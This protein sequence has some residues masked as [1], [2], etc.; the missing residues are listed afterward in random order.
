MVA[1]LVTRIT[2][3]LLKSSHLSNEERQ[4]LTSA[5]LDKLGA[6]PLHA[7]IVVDEAGQFFVNGKQLDLDT[8]RKLRES[9]R[10]MMNNFARRFVR[11]QVKYMA[12]NI[13]VH[14]NTSPD[15]GLFAKTA[16]YNFQEEDELY[17]KFIQDEPTG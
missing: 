15:Q 16:L 5:L 4:L 14:Q 11:E 10:S 8:A 3:W 2:I 13:G 1:R 12:I 9:A 7:T 6:L 17:R